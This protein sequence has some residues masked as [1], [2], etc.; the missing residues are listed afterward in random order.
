[1]VASRGNE[2]S[3]CGRR[4]LGHRGIESLTLAD[5][6]IL[7]LDNCTLFRAHTN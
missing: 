2:D 5:V 1:V 3:N 7:H 4:S 6:P